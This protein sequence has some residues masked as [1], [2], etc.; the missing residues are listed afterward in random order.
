II[1]EERKINI[2]KAQRSVIE[3]LFRIVGLSEMKA[4]N[5]SASIVDWRDKDSELSI[6]LGSA[7]D[8][9]YRNL[10][11]PYEAKDADFE[12]LDELL[13]VRGMTGEIFDEIKGFITIYGE[14]KVN[15]NTASEDVLLSLGLH[16]SVVNKILS[17]RYG[18]DMIE[19]SA[20]DNVFNSVSGITARLS[21]LYLLSAGEVANLSNLVSAKKVTVK[22]NNFMIKSIAKLD[23]K[24]TFLKIVCVFENFSEGSDESGLNEDEKI[25]YWR[26]GL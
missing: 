5:L 15:I 20:D 9:Y 8:R 18:Q 16:A 24:E 14:G 21:Q 7:E 1:D 10:R 11:D 19:A 17:F 25:R 2:N 12:V 3:R 26:E 22:S 13:L 6:P 23:K 4:Q